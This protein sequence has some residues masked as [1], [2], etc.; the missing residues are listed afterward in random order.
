ML[1][2]SIVNEPVV[3]GSG[4]VPGLPVPP[5]CLYGNTQELPLTTLINAT[6]LLNAPS[7]AEV[8]AWTL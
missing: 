8:I 6:S 1:T 7:P 5:T 4:T 3:V 2:C